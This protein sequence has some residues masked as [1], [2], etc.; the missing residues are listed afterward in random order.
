MLLF[1]ALFDRA[2]LFV[3]DPLIENAKYFKEH[4]MY[5]LLPRIKKESVFTR[6]CTFQLREAAKWLDCGLS[7]VIVCEATKTR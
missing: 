4:E 6:R 5:F 1:V 7:G 3:N 2:E